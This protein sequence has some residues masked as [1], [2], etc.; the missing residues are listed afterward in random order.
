M[1]MTDAAK[2]CPFCS[3]EP[4]AIADY[5]VEVGDGGDT[6]ELLKRICR[7]HRAIAGYAG[8]TILAALEAE[9]SKLEGDNDGTEA[10][11]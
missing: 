9:I 10:K 3:T 2:G 6:D 7:R 11:V 8:A 5:F 4:N 1:A